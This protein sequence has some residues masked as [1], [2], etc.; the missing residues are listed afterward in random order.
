MH[1]CW[2]GGRKE[3]GVRLFAVVPRD[4]TRG[5]GR[6]LEPRRFLLEIRKRFFTV[7][8]MEHW[9]CLS[10]GLHKVTSRDPFGRLPFWDLW[11]GLSHSAARGESFSGSLLRSQV[12]ALFLHQGGHQ[13]SP[14]C[15]LPRCPL[16][17]LCAQGHQPLITAP[18]QPEAKPAAEDHEK[19]AST[20]QSRLFPLWGV[21]L[22]GWAA[23]GGQSQRPL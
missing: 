8:V 19:M 23:V 15:L 11:L 14:A 18:V 1:K 2:K 12:R 5:N 3:G 7:R 16:P 17:G 22:P 21:C 20:L 6:K 10:R 9:P 13:A 4:R